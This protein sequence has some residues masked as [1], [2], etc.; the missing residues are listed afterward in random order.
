LARRF[1][2][3]GPWLMRKMMHFRI[4][5]CPFE[6]LIP[7]VKPGSSVLD[8]GCGAGLFLALLTGTVQ[9]VAGTGFDTSEP[10]IQTALRMVE[11]VRKL[12][13]PAELGF[14]RLDAAEQWPSGQFDV[15]SVIDVMHHVPPAYQDRVPGLAARSLKPGGLLLY[16]DMADQPFL[17]AA[18]NRLHDLV[19]AQQWIHYAPIDAVEEWA[20]QSGLELTY[21]EAT[22]RLWYRHELRIFRKPEG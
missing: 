10:A 8:V 17:P 20:R 7:H 3:D 12:G 16:K 13:L 21:S 22:S 2:V 4:H 5:I 1:Y 9:H 18:M 6:R 19:C 14:L 11:H 15:V